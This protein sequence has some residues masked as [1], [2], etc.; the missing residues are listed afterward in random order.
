MPLPAV[1]VNPLQFNVSCVSPGIV[2]TVP[3][4]GAVVSRKIVS[5]FGVVARVPPLVPEPDVHGLGAAARQPIA[6]PVFVP[7]KA[8]QASAVAVLLMHI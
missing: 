8:V 2:V 4:T 3:S 5:L 6:S 7:A 1:S